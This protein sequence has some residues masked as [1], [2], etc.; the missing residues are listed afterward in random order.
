[1]N[2]NATPALRTVR[3]LLVTY[4]IVGWLGFATIVLLSVTIAKHHSDLVSVTAWVH[5]LIV[6]LTGIPFVM[7]ASKAA[8]YKGRAKTRLRI[9][10]TIVPIAF[11]AGIFLLSLP[12]W[13]DIEQAICALLLAA[14]AVVYFTHK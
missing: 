3:R 13:M 9:I 12:T 6:A 7:V 11:I 8:Q 2:Q 5:G 10:L 4:A 14:A 1:M